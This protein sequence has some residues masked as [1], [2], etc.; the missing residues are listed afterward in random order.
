MSYYNGLKILSYNAV[1]N[2]VNTNRN[3]GKTWTFKYRAVKRALKHHKKTLWVRRFKK[4]VKECV[5]TFFKSSDLQKFCTV[6]FYD[7]KTN[8][9]GNIKQQGNIFYI[10]VGKQWVDF[11]KI[12]ALSDANAMRSADDIDI[13]TIIFD[14][15]TTTPNKYKCYRGNEVTDFIDLFISAKREHKITCI[16]LGNKESFNNPYFNY[17]DIPLIDNS[18]NGIKTFRNGSIAVEQRNNKPKE[19]NEYDKQCNNLLK[20]TPYGDY[21]YEDKYKL[22][23]K[24]KICNAPKNAYLYSQ[25]YFNNY[26]FGIY[27][28][29][30]NFYI[31]DKINNAKNVYCD[32]LNGYYNNEVQLLN[33]YKIYFKTFLN[34]VSNNRVYYINSAINEQI[35]PFLKWLGTIK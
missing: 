4:E 28:Q 31:T 10:K 9:N 18:F 30:D 24:I 1:Y 17:F 8:P 23:R 34:G 13:D 5:I 27:R 29:N 14:E 11:I 22:N 32:T 3:Y 15:Y 2:F 26:Y 6:S 12:V 16:F 25:I 20:G 19:N 21:L 33:R 7:A 35:Q